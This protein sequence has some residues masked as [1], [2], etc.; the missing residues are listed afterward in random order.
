MKTMDEM[1]RESAFKDIKE[2]DDFIWDESFL[3]D[4][5]LIVNELIILEINESNQY[6]S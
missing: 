5:E 2:E 4:E 6:T 1:A 3:E